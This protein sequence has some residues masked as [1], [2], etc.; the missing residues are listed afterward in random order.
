MA[1]DFDGADDELAFGTDASIDGFVSKTI[2]GWFRVDVTTSVRALLY[3]ATAF[4]NPGWSAAHTAFGGPGVQVPEF[5]HGFSTTDGRWRTST[6]RSDGELMH[7]T[8]T[9][10]NSDVANDPVIEINGVAETLVEVAAPVGTAD[11][12]SG[13]TLRAGLNSAGLNDFDGAMMSLAYDNQIW[14]AGMKNRH[15][16]HGRPGGPVKVLHPFLTDKLVNEGTATADGTAT[17][18]TMTSIPRVTR[19]GC[20]VW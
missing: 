10:N 20:G 7:I 4:A 9:Y 19:P 8:I 5:A 1:R 13:E 18:T 6:D 17:G 14:D 16:W 15:R 3:K 12:D 2:G 11:D